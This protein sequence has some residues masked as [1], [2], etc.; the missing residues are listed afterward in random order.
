MKDGQLK[1]GPERLGP[2]AA[3]GGSSPTPTDAMVIKGIYKE[4]SRSKAIEGLKPLADKKGVSVEEMADMIYE[5]TAD[6]IVEN[7]NRYLKK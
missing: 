4:G 1:I 5:K 3:F 6:I 2:A 7:I